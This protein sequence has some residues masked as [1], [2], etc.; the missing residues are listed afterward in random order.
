MIP[1]GAEGIPA[2][3]VE[4]G[5]IPREEIPTVEGG[6]PTGVTCAITRG[7]FIAGIALCCCVVIGMI[8]GATLEGG[9]PT[10]SADPDAKG[11]RGMGGT[12]GGVL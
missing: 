6:T 4:M 9:I 3:A 12:A 10:P 1:N 11:G 7:T 5:P 8:G 2:E